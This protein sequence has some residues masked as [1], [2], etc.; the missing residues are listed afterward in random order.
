MPIAYG[1]VSLLDNVA[2]VFKLGNV[3]A[4]EHYFG[5]G[6][7]LHWMTCLDCP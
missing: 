2:E 3:V 1:P 6:L 7:W 4:V 5:C